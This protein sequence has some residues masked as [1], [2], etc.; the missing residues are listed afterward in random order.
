MPLNVEKMSR[1]E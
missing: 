1:G